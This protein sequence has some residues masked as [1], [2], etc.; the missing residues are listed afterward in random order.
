MRGFGELEAVVMERIWASP[1]GATVPE[2]HE[3]LL[4]E[5]DIAYTTVMS[6]IHNLYR[7]G[8]LTRT[9]EGRKHRYRATASRAEHSADL[10]RDA[11]H[12]GGDPYAILTHFVQQ[13]DAADSRHLAELLTRSNENDTQ[14][15]RG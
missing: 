9:R 11:L 8:R 14:D 7:K 15:D 1:E 3:G 4:S 13:M 2:V 6:T 12:S 10:M 5:R